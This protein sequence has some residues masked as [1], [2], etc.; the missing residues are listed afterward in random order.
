M[1][2]TIETT[3]IGN[4]VILQGK[5]VMILDDPI[6]CGERNEHIDFIIKNNFLEVQVICKD[7]IGR[8]VVAMKLK[9]GD[10][11]S[12]IGYLADDG[13]LVVVAD[14]VSKL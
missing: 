10:T 5:I 1:T 4:L 7:K 2:A 8:E 11:V 9:K 13:D 6:T 3:K 14:S 12:V